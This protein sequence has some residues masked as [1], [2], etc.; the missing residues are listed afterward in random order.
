MLSKEPDSMRQ[1]AG[2]DAPM[3]QVELSP[4]DRFFRYFQEEVA[5]LEEK[6]GQ[7]PTIPVAGGVDAADYCLADIS[8]LSNEVKDAS[9]YIPSYDQRVYSES[10]KAL[11]EKLAETKAA[12]APRKKFA[13][14]RARQPTPVRA[15]PAAEPVPPQ[16]SQSPALSNPDTTMGG[17]QTPSNGPP[18]VSFN[19]I[20][21]SHVA[22]PESAPLEN[23]SAVASDITHCVL[24]LSS[25]PE[26]GRSFANFTIKNVTDSLLICGKVDGAAHITGIKD[27]AL[28]VSCQQFRMH[29]CTNVVVYLSCASN[30]IIEDCQD[31]RFSALPDSYAAQNGKRTD[32]WSHV[33][34]FKWLKAEQSPNW[35]ILEAGEAV[36][37]AVWETLSTKK[38]EWSLDEILKA[39]KL[40]MP[41]FEHFFA[42]G[43][44]S[45]G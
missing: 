41:K 12:I 20:S 14:K 44:E 25:P 30:P 37:E 4:N 31:I 45:L 2:G 24:D 10:I 22:I 5:N 39:T 7:L 23:S 32:M 28:V 38:H 40:L 13:F 15:S 1:D 43:L 9:S 3:R 18:V 21:N 34:D 42:Q 36:P 16:L 33:E 29:D 8:R 11:Q 26:T 19:N 35:K 27:S 6:I 17:T